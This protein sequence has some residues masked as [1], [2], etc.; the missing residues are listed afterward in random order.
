MVVHYRPTFASGIG[1]VLT[2][3]HVGGDGH[4]HSGAFRWELDYNDFTG[5]LV[6]RVGVTIVMD[7]LPVTSPFGGF[8]DAKWSLGVSHGYWHPFR[9][10]V[11]GFGSTMYKN[12]ACD[13]GWP[14]FGPLSMS[15][16]SD[17]FWLG[18][19]EVRWATWP[20]Y[21]LRYPK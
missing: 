13:V 18:T 11:G 1:L 6:P 12:Q 7:S 21:R 10:S 8:Q 16:G 20:E 3:I 5:V 19:L 9:G 4:D 15:F 2:G 14:V 17:G